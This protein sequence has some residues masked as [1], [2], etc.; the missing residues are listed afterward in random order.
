MF[1]SD[2]GALIRKW[3]L[4][5]VANLNAL[6]TDWTKGRL[7]KS[8]WNRWEAKGRPW[9]PV[10]EYFFFPGTGETSFTWECYV[11]FSEGKGEMRM[12]F[13]ASAVFR[14]PLA[15]NNPYAKVAYLGVTNFAP[16]QPHC[17]CEF[18]KGCRVIQFFNI[19]PKGLPHFCKHL[20]T[21]VLV[22]DIIK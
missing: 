11:L 8:N 18:L 13:L 1:Y 16:L 19:K 17:L 10:E 15:Q 6:L 22:G 4:E 12:L 7:W 20:S 21:I 3:T 5:E 2:M 14:V 9:L